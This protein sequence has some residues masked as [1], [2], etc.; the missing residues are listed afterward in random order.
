MN[1]G[2]MLFGMKDHFKQILT[3][4]A[5]D[6][7]GP[8]GAIPF[9]RL[10]ARHLGAFQELRERGLTWEQI[11]RLL[12][13]AGTVRADGHAFSPSHL[14][15]VFG[16]QLKRVASGSARAPGNAAVVPAARISPARPQKIGTPRASAGRQAAGNLGQATFARPPAS[17]DPRLTGAGDATGNRE[18]RRERD[19]GDDHR[20]A[21]DLSQRDRASLVTLMRQAA[22]ARRPS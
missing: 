9:E 8:A 21:K 20:P 6:Y 10:V 5:S 19:G 15:G 7:I 2:L 3:K 22:L 13:A 4:M 16:R 1:I 17:I 11:S 18:A 12:A 14:R